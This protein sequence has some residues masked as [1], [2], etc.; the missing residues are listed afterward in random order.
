[1]VLLTK[2]N[3]LA[4]KE[5]DELQDQVQKSL[6]ALRP[7]AKL[8]VDKMCFCEEIKG[9]G[10]Y[11]PLPKDYEFQPAVGNRYGELVQLY[12]ELH[13]LT[14]ELRG[15]TFLTRL[16]ST[17]RIL[18]EAGG[19]VYFADFGDREA[20]LC[21]RTPLPDTSKHYDFYVPR[22]PSGKY[23]FCFEVRDETR[24]EPRIAARELDFR[25]AAVGGP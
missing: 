9:Y 13:N 1:V 20:P 24:P 23:R 6:A 5:I 14:S 12:V 4:P 19:E 16:H 22:L 11:K 8:V 7:R 3:Q 21:T 17:I 2:K 10:D 25:V 18:D 15:G